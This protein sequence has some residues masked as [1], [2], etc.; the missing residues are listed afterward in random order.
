MPP[1]DEPFLLTLGKAAP[2]VASQGTV[3]SSRARFFL[4]NF[5]VAS[6]NGLT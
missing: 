4:S 6:V 3:L 2:G 5:K 1:L